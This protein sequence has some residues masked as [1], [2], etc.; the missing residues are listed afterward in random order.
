MKIPITLKERNLLDAI[1]KGDTAYGKNIISHN[2]QDDKLR[3][4]FQVEFVS[5]KRKEILYEM[6]GEKKMF[7]KWHV[8]TEKLELL[9][10]DF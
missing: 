1:Q 10:N 4:E 7:K 8:D 9:E 5:L 2:P 6:P 3:D